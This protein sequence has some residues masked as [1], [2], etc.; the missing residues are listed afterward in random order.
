MLLTPLHLLGYSAAPAPMTKVLLSDAPARHGARCLDGSPPAYYVRPASAPQNA[1]RFVV[2]F[3]GGGWCYTLDDCRSRSM[4]GLGSSKSYPDEQGDLGGVISGDAGLNPD[5]ATWTAVWVP[6]CDGGSYSGNL[7][8]P[9]VPDGLW[10]RGRANMRAVVTDLLETRGMASA[11][12][13]LIDGGSAGGLTTL[14]HADFFRG[15]LPAGVRFGAIGDAG[16]FR[17]EASLDHLNYTG[18]IR[19]MAAMMNA[20]SNAA[21]EAAHADDPA[22]C[23]FA[24]TVFPFLQSDMMVVEGAYDSWQLLNILGLKCS[25]C[26]QP[27]SPHPAPTSPSHAPHAARVSLPSTCLCVSVRVCCCLQTARTCRAAR[28]RRTPPSTRTA[29]RCASQ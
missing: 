16:W 7:D 10:F 18:A 5:F 8:A 25:Y 6:Y 3:Q 4:G 15:L 20:T 24:P 27:F 17:P 1:S 11:T 14:L 28:Q 22:A 13:V 23:M 26:A 9:S 29:T 2:Y 12:H 21:C 19:G